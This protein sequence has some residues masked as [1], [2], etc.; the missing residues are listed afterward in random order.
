MRK[1]NIELNKGQIT[2]DH[3]RLRVSENFITEFDLN[4]DQKVIRLREC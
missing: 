2:E 4:D 3:R 1:E